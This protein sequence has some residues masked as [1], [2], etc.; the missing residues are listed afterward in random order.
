VQDRAC[1]LARDGC[2][3]EDGVGERGPRGHRRGP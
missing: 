2:A 3:G 1:I